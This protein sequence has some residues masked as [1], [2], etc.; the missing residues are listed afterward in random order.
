MELNEQGEETAIELKGTVD[1]NAGLEYRYTK[2]LSLF[3]QL[4]NIAAL[5]YNKW[6]K[7]PTQ[8]FNLLGGLTYVF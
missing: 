2:R 1:V 7:Y 8:R 5:E 3:L 4:N 6:N